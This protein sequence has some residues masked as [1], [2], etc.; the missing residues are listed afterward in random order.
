VLDE[1]I[2]AIVLYAAE[3]AC[4]GLIICVSSLM[5]L[6][7]ANSSETLGTESAMIGFLP[8]VSPHMDEKITFFRKY[9][10]TI[11]HCALEKIV[12]RMG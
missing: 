12:P 2:L 1:L 10:S 3:F 11:R 6:A 5:I 8:C 7:V 9:L 4:V